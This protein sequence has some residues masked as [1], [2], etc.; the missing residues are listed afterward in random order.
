M[1][2]TERWPGRL[3]LMLAHCAGMVDL[4]ALPLWVGALVAHYGFDA[5]QAGGLVTLFLLSAVA[6]SLFFAPRLQRLAGRWAATAGFAV[7]AGAFGLLS[8]VQA[9]GAMAALH[10]LG[11]AG[12]GCALSFTHGTV[13]RSARPHRLFALLSAALGV[14][15]V[16]FL[17]AMSKLLALQGGALLFQVLAAIMAVA[18]LGCALSF[19]LAPAD[20][21]APATGASAPRVGGRMDS[22]VWCGALGLSCMALVNATVFS[23][24]ERM[25]ADRG[26]GAEAITG[27]FVALG[28]V[29]LLPAP[30][31][32]L[33]ERRWSARA[34][35]LAGPLVQAAL[36]LAVTQ[37]DAFVPYAGG[38]LFLAGVLIFT[39]VFAFGLI[40]RLDPSGRALAATPAMMMVG[41]AV[42]PILGGTL[43]KFHGYPALGLAAV[44]F[45]ALAVV[46]FSRARRSQ[47]PA[48]AAA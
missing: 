1:T 11:G 12:V 37:T 48:V 18:A 8:L 46:F 38:A 24:L 9:Y 39:H 7:A 16:L 23:F 17:G 25:G 44:L 14:F 30:L 40:A 42:G 27:V 29:N 4:V 31:A 28:L 5:Q 6:T 3:A 2:T 41:S 10:G 26:F 13:A 33:L 15:A 21:V 22:A 32:A 43:V 47:A 34:V 35:A 20:A 36:A 19:P 45:A